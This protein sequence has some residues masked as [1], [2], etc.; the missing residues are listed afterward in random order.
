M[1]PS[2]ERPPYRSGIGRLA[3]A[4]RY[5]MSVTARFYGAHLQEGHGIGRRALGN[6]GAAFDRAG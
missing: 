1:R 4:A 3:E 5:D 2:D 6:H